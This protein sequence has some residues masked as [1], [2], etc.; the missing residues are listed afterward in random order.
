MNEYISNATQAESLSQTFATRIGAFNDLVVGQETQALANAKKYGATSGEYDS[1]TRR[2]V[3]NA[4]RNTAKKETHQYHKTLV[5][6]TE[7][8]RYDRLK[9]LKAMDSRAIELEPLFQSPVQMLSRVALGSQE[10]SRYQEQLTGAG[11][12]EV[13]NHA[14]W[15]VAHGDKI[16]AA[17]VLSRLDNLPTDKRPI[18]AVEFADKMVGKDFREVRDALSRTRNAVQHAV[19]VN[20]DFE[21]GKVDPTAKIALALA[22]GGA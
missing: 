21:R 17:A 16:L 15:A 11:P 9:T 19:N 8:E 14:N 6:S 1:T 20:R 22:R 12:R 10:R 3:E 4:N 7:T 18:K 13:M 5:G 2:I